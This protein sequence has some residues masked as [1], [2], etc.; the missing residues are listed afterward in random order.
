MA[1]SLIHISRHYPKGRRDHPGGR[2]RGLEP[3]G[4]RAVPFA[5]N[6]PF[7]RGSYHAVSYTHLDVYKRQE[8]RRI[9][10][11]ER[12]NAEESPFETVLPQHPV[13]SVP[14]VSYTHLDVYK[15]QV[16]GCTAALT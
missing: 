3:G 15:R 9:L 11:E 4:Y 8:E 13:R 7:V 5:G 12:G 16:Q 6:V 14:A 1:L 2:F 10:E